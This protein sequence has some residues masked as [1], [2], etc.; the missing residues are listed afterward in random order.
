MYI[1]KPPFAMKFKII[2]KVQLVNL[3]FH[4]NY[5]NLVDEQKQII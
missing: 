1:M 4:A 3:I 5:S 2:G